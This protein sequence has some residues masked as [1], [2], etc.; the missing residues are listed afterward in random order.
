ML[1]QFDEDIE[2]QQLY[3]Y[4][5]F[6]TYPNFFAKRVLWAEFAEVVLQNSTPPGQFW[7]QNLGDAFLENPN[8][9]KVAIGCWVAHLE[10]S[11][12]SVSFLLEM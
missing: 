1:Y 7:W 6:S 2:E 4:R 5:K 10:K 12:R 8:G 9:R 11:G 3:T